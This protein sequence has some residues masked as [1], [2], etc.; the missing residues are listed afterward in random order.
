MKRTISTTVC[1]GM[2]LG[3]IT[4]A[5]ATSAQALGGLDLPV[6]P[7]ITLPA[8]VASMVPTVTESLPVIPAPETAPRSVVNLTCPRVWLPI[9]V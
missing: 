8:P 3:G 7:P 1:F 2:F 9:L 6:L 4:L 5:S